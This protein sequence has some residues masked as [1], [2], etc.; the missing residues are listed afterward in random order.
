MAV[1]PVT[2]AFKQEAGR[3]NDDIYDDLK[4]KKP[5]VSMVCINIFQRYNPLTA[6][7]FN[8]NFHSLEVVSR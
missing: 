8:M 3:A 5:L 1:D 7:L 2:Q 4:L 6:K